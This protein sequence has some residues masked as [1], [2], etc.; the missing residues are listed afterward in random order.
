MAQQWA[1]EASKGKE[2]VKVPKEY[3]EFADIFLDEKAK[4][5]PPTRG[6]FNHQIRFKEGAPETIQCKVYPMN[7]AETEFTRNW[8][9]DNLAG[10]IQ[11]S[12][13]EITCPSFLIKKKNGTFCMVQD[14]KPINAWTI[15]DNSPLPLIITIVEDLEGM[16][17]FSTVA[18]KTVPMFCHFGKSDLE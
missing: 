10:K 5:L 18:Q 9:Q 15:P 14:Y 12:Q 13:S 3:K 7:H 16:S 2:A 4:Q 1:I 11:E 17:L 8:I 6:E